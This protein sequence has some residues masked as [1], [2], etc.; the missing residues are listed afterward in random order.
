MKTPS[1]AAFVVSFAV[2]WTS[3]RT[4]PP[5]QTLQPTIT[6]YVT[7]PSDVNYARTSAE[8]DLPYPDGTLLEAILYVGSADMGDLGARIHESVQPD[9]LDELLVDRTGAFCLPHTLSGQI[10]EL[11]EA[12]FW[13][14]VCVHTH[15]NESRYCT[16]FFGRWSGRLDR[17]V[18]HEQLLT[19]SSPRRLMDSLLSSDPFQPTIVG[20]PHFPSS[21]PFAV[22]AE[23]VASVPHYPESL[24][25]DIVLYGGQSRPESWPQG[26]EAAV[27]V[28]VTEE[29]LEP[30]E[31]GRHGQPVIFFPATVTGSSS[32]AIDTAETY[33]LL[34]CV[35][36]E[37]IDGTPVCRPFYREWSAPLRRDH[38]YVRRSMKE[39]ADRTRP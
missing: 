36:L 23:T 29:D 39:G 11:R 35:H 7:F 37:A 10:S 8:L 18:R 17:D 28:T 12:P 31:L 5:V 38:S 16:P 21:G 1:L 6:G 26:L 14:L 25:E 33:W 30:Y 9:A 34:T 2:A 3:C 15:R 20:R 24:I 32:D 4:Q 19:E 13:Y 27:H 22:V